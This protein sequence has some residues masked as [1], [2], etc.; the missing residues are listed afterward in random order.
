MFL[1]LAVSLLALA[2]LAAGVLYQILGSRRDARL[3]TGSGRWIE[4]EDGVRLFA[5]EAG[6]GEPAVIFESGIG[7]THLNWR[8]IQNAVAEFAHTAAYDR[9]GLGW[10][11]PCRSARTPGN[12]SVELHEM[13]ARAEIQPPY[14]L[15]GHSF[16]GLVMRSFALSFPEDVAGMV[17]VDPMRCEEW[18]PLDPTKEPELRRGRRLIRVALPLARCGLARLALT[19][20]FRRWGGVWKR[21]AELPGGSGR[22]ALTRIRTEVGKMPRE[23]WPAIAA[24]WSCPA[25]YLGLRRHLEAVSSTVE[26]MHMAEPIARIPIVVLTPG[27]AEPLD[28]ESLSR[29][30]DCAR[31]VIA[32]RSAH[33]IHLDEPE[34]VIETIRAMVNAASADKLA[35]PVSAWSVRS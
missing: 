19:S 26:E 8:R 14:V 21:L 7:A 6:N 35:A 11:S 10:S 31:Q 27:S 18:P 24:H 17:L 32:S 33:W 3:L 9:A 12:V 28:E 29:I 25:F 34:L 22:Y 4:L 16:G 1:L 30:G 20:L 23:V 5:Y 13:L 15:V 2:V